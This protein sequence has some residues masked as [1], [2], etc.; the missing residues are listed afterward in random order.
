MARPLRKPIK[1]GIV[2][3]RKTARVQRRP[4]PRSNERRLVTQHPRRRI[5]NLAGGRGGTAGGIARRNIPFSSRPASVYRSLACGGWIINTGAE[6]RAAAFAA[7]ACR[8]SSVESGHGWFMALARSAK[9][10]RLRRRGSVSRKEYPLATQA[11]S[12]MVKR[13]SRAESE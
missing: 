5:L 7:S 9:R 4:A 3:V 6:A 12:Q 1:I 10:P 2:L 13:K 11:N 8:C